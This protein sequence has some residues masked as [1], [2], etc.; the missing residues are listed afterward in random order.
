MTFCKE[1]SSRLEEPFCKNI[2][3]LGIDTKYCSDLYMFLIRLN[4]LIAVL[5]I[6]EKG[7]AHSLDTSQCR[8]VQIPVGKKP[9]RLHI[10]TIQ[11]RF[12]TKCQGVATL[13][14]RSVYFRK[15]PGATS[16]LSFCK[17]QFKFQGSHGSNFWIWWRHQLSSWCCVGR[18]WP[19]IFCK[20]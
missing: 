3:F 20:L 14:G 8:Y 18:G 11:V 6:S 5:A 12:T 10:G 19:K 9:Y 1:M 13:Q 15:L 16:T 7:P 4:H 2:C 17:A